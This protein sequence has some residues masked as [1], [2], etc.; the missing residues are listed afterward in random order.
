MKKRI[1]TGRVWPLAIVGLLLLNVCVCAVTVVAALSSPISIEPD[2]YEKAM[3]WETDRAA[4]PSAF[5]W[6]VGVT[7]QAGMID[8]SVVG[9]DG[10]P[11]PATAASGVCFHQAR[12]DRRVEVAFT[13]VGDGRFLAPLPESRSGRWELRLELDTPEGRMI[14]AYPFVVPER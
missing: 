8:L 14:G 13:L 4:D 11:A 5:G 3:A 9:P 7:V 6:M 12:A 2:Y 1:S 10:R